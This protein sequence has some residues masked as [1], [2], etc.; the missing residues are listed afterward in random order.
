MKPVAICMALY[1]LVCF[2]DRLRQIDWWNIRA[3]FVGL[4]LSSMLWALSM[5]YDAMTCDLQW[6]HGIGML[7]MLM[8][9]FATRANWANGAP[10]Y[11]HIKRGQTPP[12]L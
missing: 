9:I 4:Y 3:T 7:A 6:H 1:L 5:L 12:Q 11:S 10:G 2:G 8:L